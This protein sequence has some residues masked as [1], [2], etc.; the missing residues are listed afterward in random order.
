MK[1]PRVGEAVIAT[2]TEV[3]HGEFGANKRYLCDLG[4]EEW[5]CT[6]QINRS[7]R[8]ERD[9]L[10]VGDRIEGW[11]IR[12]DEQHNKI[13]VGISDFGK[14]PPREKQAQEYLA[15]VIELKT[16]LISV[17]KESVVVPS[18]NSLSQV[19]GLFTRCVKK[20][21]WDWYFV[22]SSLGIQD[23]VQLISTGN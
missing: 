15:A 14:F 1:C 12:V 6:I 22:Y 3:G 5:L 13:A 4:L 7:S 11:V 16:A 18:M 9:L 20:D 17:D 8:V 23:D 2:V 10:Q 19:K 21:Q